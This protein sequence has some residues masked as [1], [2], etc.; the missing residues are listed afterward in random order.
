MLAVQCPLHRYH[1]SATADFYK[2]LSFIPQGYKLFGSPSCFADTISQSFVSASFSASC[3]DDTQAGERELGPG[4][5]AKVVTD[6]ADT[7]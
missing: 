6:V 1:V 5:P 7:R 2:P 3:S 4:T